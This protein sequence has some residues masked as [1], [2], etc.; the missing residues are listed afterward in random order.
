VFLFSFCVYVLFG[1][2]SILIFI[3]YYVSRIAMKHRVQKKDSRSITISMSSACVRA[4]VLLLCDVIFCK[5]KVDGD[6]EIKNVSCVFW[7]YVCYV[8]FCFIITP[9]VRSRN[10]VWRDNS[11]WNVSDSVLGL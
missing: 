3:L 11:V 7:F 2:Y 5:K 9:H 4:C 6:I 8:V 10:S 1:Q